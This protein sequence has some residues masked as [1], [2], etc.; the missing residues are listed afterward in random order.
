MFKYFFIL[1]EYHIFIHFKLETKRI[2]TETGLP[3]TKIKASLFRIE[4][5]S[6]F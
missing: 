2:E 1:I 3:K 6:H 5:G 4:L